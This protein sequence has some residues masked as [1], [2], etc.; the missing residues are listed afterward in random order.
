[1]RKSVTQPGGSFDM[2]LGG[3]NFIDD[4]LSLKH[5]SMS[6]E[7]FKIWWGGWWGRA[8]KDG[9]G[10]NY[11]VIFE[12]KLEFWWIQ[13]KFTYVQH[14]VRMPAIWLSPDCVFKWLDIYKGSIHLYTYVGKKEFPPVICY[15][16]L[17]FEKWQLVNY[18]WWCMH[19]VATDAC[20]FTRKD[21]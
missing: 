5:S 14:I 18:R 17:G 16:W 10:A 21:N 15:G 19:E 11:D 8:V 13:Y 3:D 6:P 1:M 4:E 2:G 9:T 20:W 7:M 12:S